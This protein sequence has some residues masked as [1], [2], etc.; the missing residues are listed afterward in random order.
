MGFYPI[1]N[2]PN[3]LNARISGTLAEDIELISDDIILEGVMY[4]LERFFGHKYPIGR[5]DKFIR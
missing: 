3:V 4:V 1:P 2:N 5:P